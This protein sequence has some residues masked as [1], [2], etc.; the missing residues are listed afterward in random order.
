[1]DTLEKVIDRTIYVVASGS[2][3][4]GTNVEGSDLDLKGVCIPTK[5]Y[6]FGATKK[7]EQLERHEPGDLNITQLQKF[8]NLC[9]D[10]N[11]N[12][13]EMLFVDFDDII[14]MDRFGVELRSW[15]DDFLSKRA[16]HTF[17]GYAHAQLKKM[18]ARFE[19]D[20][21]RAYKFGMHAV[22]LLRM[23][24]EIL[25]DGQCIVRRPDAPMLREIRNGEWTLDDIRSYCEVLEN[26][27]KEFY[28]RSPLPHHPNRTH[29]DKMVVYLTEVY[30]SEKR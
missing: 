28:T 20:G 22:R 29:I 10:C 1:M 7:F 16:L 30:L 6:Y 13:I 18:N 4:Y 27:C 25:R 9:A 5:D 11:P 2:F 12:V 24:R 3:A 19:E 14:L 15:R 26:D 23:C 21:V 17:T 8:V